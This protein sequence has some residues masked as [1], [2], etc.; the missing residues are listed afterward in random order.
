MKPVQYAVAAF[1]ALFVAA[2]GS[3]NS[4]STGQKCDADSTFAQVQQ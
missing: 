1:A 3:D 2:C 4:N